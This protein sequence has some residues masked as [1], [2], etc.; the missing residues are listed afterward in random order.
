MK[1]L[2]ILNQELRAMVR[3]EYEEFRQA[4]LGK[5]PKEIYDMTQEIAVKEEAAALIF[6]TKF[7]AEMAEAMLKTGKVLQ[8]IYEETD[9]LSWEKLL[10]HA[11]ISYRKSVVK[12][13]GNRSETER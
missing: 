8:K 1:D 7:S 10:M 4:V 5:S 12:R 13:C 3:Q 9:G 2:K 11:M 6:N